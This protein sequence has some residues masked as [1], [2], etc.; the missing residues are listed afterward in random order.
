MSDPTVS[1]VVAT[2][3]G[4]EHVGTLL[5]AL[6]RQTFSREQLE[7]VV[8]DNGS[9]DGTTELLRTRA[10]TA[11]VL[12]NERNLGFAAATNQ[13]ARV[14]AGRY[15]ALLNNDM[16]PGERWLE[17][18]VDALESSPP[19]VVC[20]ASRIESWD[21]TRVDFAGGGVSFNGIGYQDGYGAPVGSED[22][23]GAPDRLLFPC[24]GAMIVDRAVFHEVGGFDDEFFA[25]YEDVDF[26]WRLWVLGYE[27]GFCPEA[28]VYH[29]SGAT[30]G[31][32]AAHRKL[33]LLERNALYALVKNY[34][35]ETLARVLPA[36]LLLL[37]KRIGF[38]SGVPREEFA[39][40]T[41]DA[42][43]QPVAAPL[44]SQVA[45][46]LR[47]EG[48]RGIARR[49]ASR[50]GRRGAVPG[51]AQHPARVEAYAGVAAV[52][53]L[54][55]ALPRLFEKRREI[56][57]ARRRSDAELF[58]R[59]PPRFARELDHP[60]YHAA[61]DAVVDTLGVREHFRRLREP[62]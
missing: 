20:V 50:L 59:F 24:G 61:Y 56:Q 31:R 58:S 40:V 53:D 7:L 14:A 30:G 57:E 60:V 8:V 10:P 18:M 6:E 3:N 37:V 48:P 29:H 41:D 4:R 49:I 17:R 23:P 5:E 51:P 34:E 36:A 26:G 12:Q 13:G 42:P 38:H 9:S 35:D 44:S 21:G 52:E 2:F 25:F 15:L 33:K 39:F 45:R 62:A 22:D 11:R 47:E 27:V 54:V 19:E 43:P 16:R 32:A 1:I 55:D 28:V 46:V